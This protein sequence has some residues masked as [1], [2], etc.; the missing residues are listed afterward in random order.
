MGDKV[1]TVIESMIWDLRT[2]ENKGYFE[3]SEVK[4]ILG[5]REDQEYAMNKFT[6][7]PLDFLKAIEYEMGLVSHSTNSRKT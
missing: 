7:T 3:S 4:E 6:S 2:M 5:I 1:R